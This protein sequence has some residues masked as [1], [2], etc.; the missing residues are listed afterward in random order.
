LKNQTK[1]IYSSTPNSKT[2][3]VLLEIENTHFLSHI[4]PL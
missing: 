1:G 4:P 3:L 2:I